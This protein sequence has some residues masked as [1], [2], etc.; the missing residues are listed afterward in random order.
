MV[1]SRRVG[2]MLPCNLP[3]DE[4]TQFARAAEDLG[5]PELWL[6]EDLGYRGGIAQAAVALATTESIR[7]RIGVLPAAARNVAFA[8]MEIATLEELFPGRLDIAIGHGMPAW[9]RS[10]NAWPGSPLSHLEGYI[11]GL[12]RHLNGA[13]PPAAPDAELGRQSVLKHRV[14]HAPKVF[15]GVRRPKSLAVS[16]RI[17]DGTVLSEPAPPEWVRSALSRIDPSGQHEIIAYNLAI[18]SDDVTTA[19]DAIRGT[20]PLFASHDWKPQIEVLDFAEEFRNLRRSLPDDEFVE[21]VPLE[22]IQQLA[23]IGPVEAVRRRF[24]DIEAAGATSHVLLPCGPDKIQ[25]L[26]ALAEVLEHPLHPGE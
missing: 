5:F 9:M 24:A 2:V 25:A 15:A 4:F 26:Q 13:L 7:I 16:G 23:L 11:A 10:V 14:A 1:D 6:A 19:A 18:V 22:W 3:A 17:A 20:L 21:S 12:K 8:A